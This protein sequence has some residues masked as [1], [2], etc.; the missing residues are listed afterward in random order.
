[1]IRFIKALILLPVAVAVVLLAVAN[2]SPVT[3]SLDPFSGDA[4]EFAI[5]TPLFAVIFAAVI[6]GVLIGG[7]AT[8]IAQGKHRRARRRFKR[9]IVYLRQE[10]ER[11]RTQIPSPGL[12]ALSSSHPTF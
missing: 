9:E 5:Q 6:A 11:L 4:P 12:P 3:V 8:W 2:R 10:A 1:M 7:T